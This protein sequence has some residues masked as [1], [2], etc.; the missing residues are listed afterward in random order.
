MQI[1]MALRPYQSEIKTRISEAWDS[2]ARNVLAVLPTGGGK[3]VVK[4]SI[5]NDLNAPACCIAHRRELVSQI[6]IALA[7]EGVRHRIIA[8]D[9]VIKLCARLQ[10]DELG[11]SLVYPDAAVAVAGVDSL[12]KPNHALDQWGRRVELWVQDEAHHLLA[13]N[14]WG[15]ALARFPNAR[16][17][18][19]TATPGRA[20][21]KGLGR[22]AHG[23]MDVMIHG[24]GMRDLIRA[25]YLTDY[26]IIAPG[27][28]LDGLKTG[29]SGDF[30]PATVDAAIKH[31][32][33]IGQI[34]PTWLR[35]AAGKKTVVFAHNL[36]AAGEI[37]DEFIAAGFKAACVSAKTPD[38][39]RVGLLHKFRMGC[40]DAIVNVDLFGEGFDLPAIECVIMARPTASLGLYMQQFGRVLRLMDGKQYGLVIDHVG[41]VLR[42]GLPDRPRHWSLD[43]REK[44]SRDAPDDVIPTRSCLNVQ[45]MQVYERIH[46]ACPYC[47]HAPAPSARNGPEHVDGDLYELDAETLARLRGE[48]DRITLT[49][50]EVAAEMRGKYALVIAQHA[51]ANRHITWQRSQEA[52]RAVIDQWSGYRKAE[53]LDDRA[54]LR[55]FYFRFGLDV[56]SAHGLK[57][58][59]DADELRA[60]VENN[61]TISG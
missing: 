18:G 5:I 24:P 56:L 32:K 23:V 36:L 58:A 4:A 10:V 25:G 34:V 47:G 41:N 55:L 38:A 6:S 60:R 1:I 15:Q 43:A 8:P 21:G 19:V 49:P 42:H 26:R 7:R 46:H 27:A 28:H 12:L 52:L 3:T 45:C 9:S 20:D 37:A 48:A 13:E 44:R 17:L 51:A 30:T 35:F 29:A 39:E 2:G 57:R 50:A 31:S 59:A 61:L 53:G 40:L 22:H 11:R 16:G 14:K 54:I 33:V